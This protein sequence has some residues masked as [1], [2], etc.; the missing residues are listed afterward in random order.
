MSIEFEYDLRKLVK[1]LV[2]EHSLRDSLHIIIGVEHVSIKGTCSNEVEADFIE[3]L[4]KFK[5]RNR[6]WEYI[7]ISIRFD[8][9]GIMSINIDEVSKENENVKCSNSYRQQ[10]LQLV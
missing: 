2:K 1:G 6:I 9:K 3:K 10:Q 5:N 7:E 8:R 4:L